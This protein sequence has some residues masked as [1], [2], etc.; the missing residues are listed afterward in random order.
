M[1]SV[2][3][4]QSHKNIHMLRIGQINFINCLP[5]NLPLERFGLRDD[6]EYEVVE[7][8]PAFL[9]EKLKNGELDLAPISSFEYLAN[10]DKYEILD[11]ISISAKDS[12]DSV[13]F[14]CDLDFWAKEEKVI[15]L[16]NKSATSVNLLK[17]ILKEHYKFDLSQI[18]F[19][20][21][22]LNQKYDAKL[23]IGD[24]ALKEDKTQYEE[25]ID[26]GS[27]WKEITGLPMVFGLWT[28]NKESE[29]YKDQELFKFI[30][31]RFL[32]LRD[33]GFGTLYPDMIIEAFK[34]SGL[35]RS[36]LKTYFNNLDYSFSKE[37]KESL[38]SFHTSLQRDSAVPV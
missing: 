26:L 36:T 14:F 32:E 3:G 27:K 12:A 38:E 13:L 11:G 9:N 16:T 24:E 23:L 8:S 21:F 31:Q 35:N 2:E 22:D 37:H 18:R 1:E 15:H 34:Q 10:K 30:N 20:V 5:V 6:L 4:C 17:V 29:L 33:M 19:E 25:V 7:G 28:V